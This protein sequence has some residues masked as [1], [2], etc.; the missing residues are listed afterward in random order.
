MIAEKPYIV[1]SNGKFKLMKPH[2]ETNKQSTTAKWLNADEIDFSNVYVASEND[3]AS[4]INSKL[5]A[6]NHLL[7]Q[8][9][10]YMLDAALKVSKEG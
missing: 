5:A 8:P 4:T 9:G 6:G 3:S 1:E 10:R 2:Y 7:L